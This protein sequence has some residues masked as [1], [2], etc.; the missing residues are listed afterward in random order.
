MNGSPPLGLEPRQQRGIA[1]RRRAYEEAIRQFGDRNVEEVRVEDIV[2]AADI[3][4]GTFYRYFPR[5]EDVLLS[6]AV[7]HHVE[8]LAPMVDVALSDPRRPAR[9][10]AL[11]LFLAVLS[12]V[13]HPPRLHAAIV[14]ETIRERDRFVA[15]LGDDRLELGQLVT[16][17]VERGQDQ[18]VVRL[19][20][21]ARLLGG[22]LSTGTVF[23]TLYGYYDGVLREPNG[24]AAMPTPEPIVTSAFQILWRGIEPDVPSK[25]NT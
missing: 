18:G 17:I 14:R 3:G 10:I 2:A 5:K 16:R 21:D 12:P 11:Q 23:T 20:T 1:A 22:V 15:L 6:A 13:E 9:A 7:H 24:P 8:R 19:D 4:W 25:P